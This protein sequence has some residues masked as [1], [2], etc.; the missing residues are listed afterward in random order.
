[1][2]YGSWW[3]DFFFF[4]LKQALSEQSMSLAS[5]Y[6][7]EYTGEKQTINQ[8]LALLHCCTVV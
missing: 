5:N 3:F 4:I 8:L 1:M 2:L 7:F 6:A